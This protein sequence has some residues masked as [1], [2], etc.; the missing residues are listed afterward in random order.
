ML[1]MSMEKINLT[2]TFK[3]YVLLLSGGPDNGP[4][5]ASCARFQRENTPFN[6]ESAAMALGDSG[7][8]F[9]CGR[10]LGVRFIAGSDGRC[11]PNDG[12]QCQSC[13][14]FQ[15]AHFPGEPN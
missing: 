5:C 7:E 13:R 8:L 12:P 11:G 2:S 10:N 1:K 3:I 4:Q 6:D 9:Y 15:T 14:R